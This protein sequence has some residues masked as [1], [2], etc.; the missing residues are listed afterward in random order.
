MRI[1]GLLMK[2]NF[3]ISLENWFTITYIQIKKNQGKINLRIVGANFY[4]NLY[5][6]LRYF[7]LSLFSFVASFFSSFKFLFENGIDPVCCFIMSYCSCKENEN[8]LKFRI[9]CKLFIDNLN[10][11]TSWEFIFATTSRL[12]NYFPHIRTELATIKFP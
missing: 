6:R 5:S 7:L 3:R 11:E 2:E 1:S 9:F 8:N 4:K 10:L 12:A